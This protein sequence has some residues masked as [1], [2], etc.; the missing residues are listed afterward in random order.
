M[1]K[2]GVPSLSTGDLALTGSVR[3][4]MCKSIQENLHFHQ[5]TH[6][7]MTRHRSNQRKKYCWDMLS[8]LY[9]HFCLSGW[10]PST[11]PYYNPE[12]PATRRN[13]VHPMLKSHLKSYFNCIHTQLVII[14]EH[15]MLF[16]TWNLWNHFEILYKILEVAGPN[17]ELNITSCCHLTFFLSKVP[18]IRSKSYLIGQKHVM[19]AEKTPVCLCF[20]MLN[21]LLF[22][23]E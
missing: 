22:S 18:N 12:G 5:H 17:P 13:L 16:M 6:N 10:Y 2:I 23:I 3:S 21:R 9:L 15:L 11:L 1:V 8:N 19:S 4:L 14:H 7:N 20:S